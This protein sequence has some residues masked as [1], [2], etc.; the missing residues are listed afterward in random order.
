[1]T[2]DEFPQLDN[3][4]KNFLLNESDMDELFEIPGTAQFMEYETAMRPLSRG[5]YVQPVGVNTFPFLGGKTDY[6]EDYKDK[7]LSIFSYEVYPDGENYICKLRVDYIKHHTVVAFPTPLLLKGVPKEITYT[8]T[9]KNA[10]DVIY[11]TI[12]VIDNT[13]KDI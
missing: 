4:S 8:I 2:I 9:S 11:G 3:Y 12:N 5:N 6:S 7:L 10:A 1:M 13:S